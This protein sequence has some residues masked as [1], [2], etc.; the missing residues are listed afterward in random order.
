M[1]YR[2]DEVDSEEVNKMTKEMVDFG[3]VVAGKE[4]CKFLELN[5]KFEEILKVYEDRGNRIQ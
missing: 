4:K 2:I 3:T 1:V 5:E